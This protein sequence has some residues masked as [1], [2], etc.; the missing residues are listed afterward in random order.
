[1]KN[2]NLSPLSYS[3]LTTKQLEI[4]FQQKVTHENTN[5]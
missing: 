5:S 2:I 4:I 3:P 1:M